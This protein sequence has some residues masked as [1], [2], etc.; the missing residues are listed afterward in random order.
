ATL[1]DMM[2]ATGVL[3]PTTMVDVLHAERADAQVVAGLLPT[4]GMPIPEAV[5]RLHQDWGMD[6]LDA[7]AALGATVAE[8]KSAG[9]TPVELLAA[10]PR[11]ILRSLDSRESTWEVA[12]ATLL[13][14]GYSRGEAVA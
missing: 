8:L 7:G 12:A 3:T 6:R 2:M 13:E 5:L 14:S 9:C 10:A 4:I 1:V 11:E